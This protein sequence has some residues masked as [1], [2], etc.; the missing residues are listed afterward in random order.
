[1]APVNGDATMPSGEVRVCPVCERDNPPERARCVCGATLAG[2]D[3]TLRTV[4]VVAAAA[5]DD[6]TLVR[7]ADSPA[8]ATIA[9]PH[10]DC[11]QSNPAGS[12][13]CLYCNRPLDPGAGVPGNRV[14][15]SALRERYRVIDAFPATGGEADLLLVAD[16]A[17]GERAVAKIYRHGIAPDFR[18]LDLLAQSVGD[19]VVR[20]LAHGSSDGAAYELLEYV[21]GGTLADLLRAGPLPM[22]DIRRVV[23][24]VAAALS[25]IHAQRILHRD[26]KPENILVRSTSPLSLA[27]TDFGI[28]SLSAATQHFTTAARTTKYAPPEALTGVLDAKS[29]WW[30][31]G[32]IVLEAASGRHPF[33]GLNEQV[34]SHHLATRPIDVRGVFDDDLRLL[35]RGLLLRE[36]ARRFGAAEVE[37]WLAGD[38]TLAVDAD[39]V[40]V[41]TV[42]RPYRIAGAEATS[43]AEL[44]VVLARHWDAARRDLARGQVARWLEHELRDYDLVRAVRDVQDLRGISDDARLQKFLLAAAPDLP[45]VWRGAGADPEALLASAAAA[46]GGDEAARDWLDG[47]YRDEALAAFAGAGNAALGELDRRWRS[48]WSRFVELCEAARRAEEKW[49]AQPRDVGGGAANATVSFDDLAFVASGKLAP[50]PQ[51]VVNGPLL[52]ALGGGVG[53]DALRGDVRAALGRIAGLCP[54]FDAFWEAVADDPVGVVV[55]RHVAACAEDDAMLERRRRAAAAEAQARLG[56]QVLGALRAEVETVLAIVPPGDDELDRADVEALSAAFDRLQ[57]ASR[58][59]EAVGLSDPAFEPARRAAERLSMQA[60]AVQQTLAEAQSVH[61]LNAIFVAPQRLLAAA[62]F[63]AFVLLLRVPALIVLVLGL[64]VAVAG[65]RWYAGFRAT[66]DVLAKLKQFALGARTFLRMVEGD[67]AGR[68]EAN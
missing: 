22:A 42:V 57:A 62:A 5:G 52:L 8:S 1:V 10:A 6:A 26:L 55:A 66:E 21:P 14:L 27:L 31:L 43:A 49:R 2:I 7:P 36:P 48:A 61:G 25:G 11:A 23:A 51:R 35:C 58:N 33:D 18:L 50:P 29:D 59:L 3:F 39:A 15:P 64:A 60:L 53:V 20:V 67:S 63:A 44:A 30:S 24:E 13:R 65:Y 32:M 9:C 46:A 37:R 28:A 4:P 68:R 19:G 12:T 38:H 40:G 54:W 34:M 45:P 56:T 16:A 47:L 41:A 17:T